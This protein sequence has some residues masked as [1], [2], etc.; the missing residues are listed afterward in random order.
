[1]RPVRTFDF[2]VVLKK[3]SN[4]A[5]DTVSLLMLAIAVVFFL[6][7]FTMQLANNGFSPALALL[8]VWIAGIVGWVLFSNSQKKKGIAPSYRFVLML[9]AWGWFMHHAYLH[10]VAYILAAAY[11]LASLLE[12]SLKV[13]PEWAFDE[14]EIVFNSFPQKKYGWN[15]VTNVVLRFGML[16]IDF[17]NN[18]I[19]QG[20][21]NDEVPLEVENDFNEFCK[22]Q[23]DKVALDKF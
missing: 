18:K 14:N 4:K 11:L 17:K 2:I 12:K 21:V 7:S 22:A 9:A 15:E 20:E 13:T 10:A 19:M 16:T 1:M 3:T 6:Y 8:L 5:I 23:L